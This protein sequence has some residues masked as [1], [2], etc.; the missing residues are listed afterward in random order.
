MKPMIVCPV[1]EHS[2]AMGSECEQC[3]KV[4]ALVPVEAL[5]EAPPPAGFEV[6][7]L[8]DASAPELPPVRIADLEATPLAAGGP[9]LPVQPPAGLEL[10][11]QAPVGE[12]TVEMVGDLDRAREEPT[13]KTAPTVGALRCRYCQ[14]A[15]ADG[16]F[17]DRC[18][19]RLPKI[20]EP[21][22]EAL[23]GAASKMVWT[24]CRACGAPAKGGSQCG[25]CGREVPMPP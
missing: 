18:G 4:L 19:M 6:T 14:H 5:P 25:D 22:L 23:P 20:P 3:G 8:G 15:Q 1:C 2:Q 24:R 10:S 12:V 7:G 11:Q 17:C 21:D 13:E 9:D 16:G